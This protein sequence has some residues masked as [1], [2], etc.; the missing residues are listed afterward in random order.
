MWCKRTIWPK[1]KTVKKANKKLL[2]ESK[3]TTAGIEGI[4]E[5]FPPTVTSSSLATKALQKLN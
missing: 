3:A 5:I 4:S 1:K 2:N